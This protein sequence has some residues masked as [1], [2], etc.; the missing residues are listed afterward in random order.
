MSCK[1]SCD[2]EL[3]NTELFLLETIQSWVS[4]ASGHV[5][6]NG[7]IHNL[8]L[9]VIL[10]KDTLLPIYI[11]DLLALNLQPKHCNLCLNEACLTHVFSL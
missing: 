3:A 4:A 10:F 1:A 9:C 11:V 2:T 5:S 6:V 7:S 8:V